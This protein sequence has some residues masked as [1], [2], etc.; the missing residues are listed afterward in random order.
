MKQYVY[1]IEKWIRSN[2]KQ[3]II[4]SVVVI[5]SVGLNMYI[6]FGPNTK[7]T[8][9]FVI[10]PIANPFAKHFSFNLTIF[11]DSKSVI[12]PS[13]IGIDESLWKNHSL[14]KYGSHGRLMNGTIIPGMAPLYTNDNSGLIKVGSLIIRNYTL[15]DFFNVWGVNFDG[16][17][18]N[19]SVNG[20]HIIDYKKYI[21]QKDDHIFLNFT[22]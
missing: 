6:G 4:L 13:Q 1:N 8:Q 12:I 16:K 18:I 19:A 15:G 17:N 22:T 10:K 14:D 2:Y 5:V 21:P 7:S 11:K 3:L 20:K 9:K